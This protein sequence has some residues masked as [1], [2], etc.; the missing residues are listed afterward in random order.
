MTFEELKKEILNRA[1]NKGGICADFHK[2]SSATTYAE[3]LE[4]SKDIV[5]WIW[6]TGIIDSDLL[7]QFPSTDLIN[8]NIY[9]NKI[10]LL[11]PERPI[12]IF[13]G[14]DVHLECGKKLQFEVI[15]LGGKIEINLLENS[16][17]KIKS[18]FDSEINVIQNDN[19]ISTISLTDRTKL[20][21]KSNQETN[22]NIII[23]QFSKCK[24][25][26]YGTSFVNLKALEKTEIEY[27][28]FDDSEIIVKVASTVTIIESPK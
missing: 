10:S 22:S 21:F 17:T 16:Y 12:Y 7:K 9:T 8:A 3:I 11:N 14:A 18:Y 5:R 6:N 24:I 20:D 28:N 26:T 15:C 27:S 25:K 2:I 4:T 13:S 19:S 1:R 23:N